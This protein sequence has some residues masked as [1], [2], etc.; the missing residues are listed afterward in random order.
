[1]HH[2]HRIGLK[3]LILAQE[4]RV[5]TIFVASIEMH[6]RVSFVLLYLSALDIVRTIITRGSVGAQKG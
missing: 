3:L 6:M 4:V 1:M 2:H 5:A